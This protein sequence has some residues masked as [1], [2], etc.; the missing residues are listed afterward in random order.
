MM[1]DERQP[2]NKGRKFPAEILTRDE[3]Q[4]LILASSGQSPTGIRNRALIVVLYRAGLRLAEALA[5]LPGD[6][7]PDGTMRVAGR[8]EANSRT[9]GLD[10]GA[11]E[12]VDVWLRRRAALG[13]ADDVPVFCTLRGEPIKDAY[14]RALLPRLA[15]RAGIAKRVH[16]L[17]LRN[18]HAAELAAEGMPTRLIQAQLGHGS[19][20]TT[21]RYLD[22]VARTQLVQAMRSRTWSLAETTGDRRH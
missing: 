2:A 3:V 10:P 15:R 4:A 8:T 17:G 16:A 18:T 9:L 6:I 12:V 1:G 20:A 14:I 11:L 5:L 22:R 21:E 13:L 7:D 19:L